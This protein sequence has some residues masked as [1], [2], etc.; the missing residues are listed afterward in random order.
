LFEAFRADPAGAPLKTPS[1]RIEIFSETIDGFAYDD[2][3]GHPAWIEPAEWLGSDKAARHPLHMLSN[4]P[5]H[6][7]HSQMDFAPASQA[8]KID[9]REPVW[10]HPDDAAARG[11]C[12]GDVVR[13]YN[14]RGA[15]LAGAKVTDGIRPGV[16]CLAT[17]AWFDPVNPGEIGSLDKHGNPNVLTLDKGTSKLAQSCI[18]QSTLVEIERYEADPPPITAFDSPMTAAPV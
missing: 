9:D 3:P 2:C 14:D 1:G 7:L 13:L 6:R 5:R 17:G 10:I 16:V 8:S 4:Q 12:D 11:I 18:A 15:C